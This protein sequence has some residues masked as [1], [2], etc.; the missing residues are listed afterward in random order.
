MRDDKSLAYFSTKDIFKQKKKGEAHVHHFRENANVDKNFC[1]EVLNKDKSKSLFLSFDTINDLQLW[2]S[3][4]I[5]IG[6]AHLPPGMLLENNNYCA[7]VKAKKRSASVFGG[8]KEEKVSSINP[9]D[10]LTTT[11]TCDNCFVNNYLDFALWNTQT[12]AL[13][14]SKVMLD[15][16]TKASDLYGA[17]FAPLDGEALQTMDGEALKKLGIDNFTHRFDLLNNL[18]LLRQKRCMCN[19]S[20]LFTCR[21]F[22]E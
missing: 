16:T 12:V 22:I 13:W 3:Y 4:F 8:K 17:N 15:A 11:G 10:E 2:I 7:L 14:L 19:M 1:I 9:L 18:A 21:L 6:A 20:L 5:K